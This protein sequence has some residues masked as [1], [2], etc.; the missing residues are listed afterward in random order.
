ML[1]AVCGCGMGL[2]AVAADAGPRAL[3]CGYRELGSRVVVR[4]VRGVE[5]SSGKA[6]GQI[7]AG[8]GPGKV[9]VEVFVSLLK[10][11]RGRK[12]EEGTNL[13]AVERS[14]EL[15]R[16]AE[17]ERRLVESRLHKEESL[18]GHSLQQAVT[19]RL[20]EVIRSLYGLL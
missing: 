20:Q 1:T 4:R 14:S 15:D 12:S 8:I 5:R 16:A 2:R 7:G 10:I 18:G 19:L 17:E 9:V 13:E 6:E 11:N 3:D